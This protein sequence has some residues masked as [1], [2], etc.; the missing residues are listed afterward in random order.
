MYLPPLREAPVTATD[1][2]RSVDLYRT[3]SLVRTFEERLLELR[4]AGEVIGPVHPYVGEEAVG[5]G[6]LSTLTPRDA[7]VSNYRGHGHAIARGVPL[8]PL[9]LE[10]TGKAGGLCGG[11]AAA[12]ISSREHNLLMSSGIIGAGVPVAAG[13]AL[14]AQV[15]GDGS[16]AV[17]FIGDGSLGAGQVH[18]AFNMAAVQKLPL[19]VVCE[20]NG[21]QGGVRTETVFPQRSL[22]AVPA[23]HGLATEEVDGTDV[24]AVAEAAERAVLRAREGGGPTFVQAWTYLARFHLQFDKPPAEWRPDEETSAW[25][26]RDPLELLASRLRTW[27]VDDG[28]LREAHDDAARRVENAVAH[29]RSAPWPGPEQ[30]L[31]HVFAEES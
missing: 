1:V 9:L 4:T 15:R 12:L 13:A 27:G 25:A 24:H 26:Q 5:V 23:A 22:L 16:V 28:L 11:K 10:L 31:T 29:A 20:H 2:P 30:V 7:I 21:Y 18:E 6:V 8:E 17:V 3:M 19:V 14:A